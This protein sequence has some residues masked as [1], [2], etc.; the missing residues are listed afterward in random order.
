MLPD[1]AT[2]GILVF[3]MSRREYDI[4]ITVNGIKIVQV[5]VDPH[6]EVKHAGVLNDQGGNNGFS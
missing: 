2:C 3:I 5:V 6:Y 1:M 4:H